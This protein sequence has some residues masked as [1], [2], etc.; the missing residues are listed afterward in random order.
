MV[1][2]R[3]SILFSN[4]S[5]MNLFTDPTT[6]PSKEPGKQGPKGLVIAVAVVAT[7]SVLG[8]ALAGLMWFKWRDRV[9]GMSYKRQEDDLVPD[10]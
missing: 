9:A 7:L 6:A 3:S 5:F 10:A 4:L 2:R 8:L 1:K